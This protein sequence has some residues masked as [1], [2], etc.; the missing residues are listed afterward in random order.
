MMNWKQRIY[1]E[2]L[3][4]C[5]IL[6]FAPSHAFAVAS[7]ARQ[8]G[9]A[10]SACHTTVPELT[11]M[12]R[13]FKLN[14]YT[15]TGMQTITSKNGPTTSG[16]SLNTFLPLSAFIMLSNTVTNKPQPGAQNGNY[17]FPQ[18]VSLYLAGAFSTHTG[19]FI[20]M[21]Y[22]TQADHFGMDMTDLRYANQKTI[23]GKN[24]TYGVTFNNSPTL[25]DLWHSTPVWSYPFV[26][27]DIAPSP[28]ASTIIDGP[29]MT[30]VAGL[31]GYAMWN[32]HLYGDFTIYRSEHIGGAQPNTGEMFGINIRGVAP[33]WRVAWQQ[34]KGNN[35]LMV[36]TYGMHVRSSPS[37]VVGPSDTYT[38]VAADAQYERI[39]PTL[40][41]DLLS[42][43]G[44]YIHESSNLG[45]TFGLG[46]AAVPHHELKTFRLNGTYHFG[47]KYAASLGAFDTAGAPDPML[48][49]QAPVSGSANGDPKSDGYIANFSYWPV[50]NIQ[51][52]AQYTGY[53]KFNGASAN[54]DGAGR[55]ASDN[56]SLYLVLWLIF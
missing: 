56:N 35:Y 4:F 43:R 16:L 33:Y 18:A 19:G 50:Q 14:G 32:D 22:D 21:T 20:Q 12:G 25:E 34:T 46:G 55:K 23:H 47:N 7:Y 49:A 8:T 48:Y 54:Y 40:H 1:S 13:T 24:V 26:G 38:D 15:M 51:L 41:N 37:A 31:G 9:L 36:G 5:L 11:P 42:I 3:A 10:C 45:A 28:S 27:S 53:A 6:I 2:S 44:T 17:E 30:D 29:L 52:A 39:F